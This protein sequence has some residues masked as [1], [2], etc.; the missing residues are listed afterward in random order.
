M[1]RGHE[2]DLMYSLSIYARFLGPIFLY[3]F[4]EKECNGKKRSFFRV[5]M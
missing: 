5:W 3:V 4:L 2:H 1:S